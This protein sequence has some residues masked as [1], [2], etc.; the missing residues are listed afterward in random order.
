MLPN[1]QFPAYLVTFTEEIPNRNLY[2]LC[3]DSQKIGS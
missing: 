2:F 1:P 3:S